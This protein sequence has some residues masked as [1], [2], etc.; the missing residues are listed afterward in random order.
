MREQKTR[1]LRALG[2]LGADKVEP[3]SNPE[4]F[5]M[6]PAETDRCNSIS[7]CDEMFSKE[8]IERA[9][10]QVQKNK[11]A[12]GTDGMTVYELEDWW[13]E[14]GTDEEHYIKELHYRPKPVRKV[15]IPKPN[16]GTRTLGI[17]CV[18]DRMIQ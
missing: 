15:D 1:R 6:Q 17:P 10:Y 16:G 2:R 11:G 3:E 13:K 9:M 5:G 7:L 8:N 18:V 14:H 12:P 4:A